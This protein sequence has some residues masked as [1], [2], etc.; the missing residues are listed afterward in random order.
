MKR[1]AILAVSIAAAATAIAS[2][3]TAIGFAAAAHAD[4]AYQFQSPSGNISCHLATGGVAC[5]ISD[6]TYVPP[7]PPPCGQHLAWG[8]RFALE[9]GKAPVMECHGDTLRIPGEQTLNYGQTLSVGAIT[10]DSETSG[11][12]CTDTST[13]HFFRVSRDSY[14]LG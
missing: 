12:T 5:D 13:R 9:Q 3:A 2:T 1:P 14:Q 4:A 6:F 10:C 7:P 11:M 8:S